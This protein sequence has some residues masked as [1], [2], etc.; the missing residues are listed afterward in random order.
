MTTSKFKIK[1]IDCSSCA[2]VIEGICEDTAG[3]SK[4]VVNSLKRTLEV[5]HD[6]SVSPTA[7]AKALETEGYPV[8]QI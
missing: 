3:V 5:S 8:E 1:R 2:M 7:L 4:A 6:D